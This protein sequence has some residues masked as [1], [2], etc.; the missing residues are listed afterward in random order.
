MGSSRAGARASDRSS[1][2]ELVGDQLFRIDT[3]PGE[4]HDVAAERPEVVEQL[5]EFQRQARA[6]RSL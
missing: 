2:P 1:F 6:P 4:K 5:R 3:D